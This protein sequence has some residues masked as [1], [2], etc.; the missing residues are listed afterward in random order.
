VSFVLAAAALL[1]VPIVVA[2][3]WWVIKLIALALL[4]GL[5]RVFSKMGWLP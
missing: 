1:A 5:F 3:A 4:I 2:A